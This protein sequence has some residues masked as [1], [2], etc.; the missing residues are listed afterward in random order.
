MIALTYT[1]RHPDTPW[2]AKVIALCVVA[3]AL[4][5]IDLSPDFIPVLRLLDDLILSPLGSYLA[6]KLIPEAVRPASAPR[7]CAGTAPVVGSR[8]R[9]HRR[10]AR[11]VRR[12]SLLPVGVTQGNWNADHAL[13]RVRVGEPGFSSWVGSSVARGAARDGLREGAG[14]SAEPGRN[15]LLAIA[16]QWAIDHRSYRR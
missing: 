16:T 14:A 12:A 2:Y 11:R 10:L 13:N 8:G 7:R 6:L 9:N 3:Y 4:S 1:Q 15:R 5:P